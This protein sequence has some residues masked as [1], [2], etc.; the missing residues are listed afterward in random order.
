MLPITTAMTLTRSVS[1]LPRA[2][3]GLL[4]AVSAIMKGC[5]P[6][7]SRTQ[8][9]SPGR[10]PQVAE[11][12]TRGMSGQTAPRTLWGFGQNKRFG[13]TGPGAFPA[14]VWALGCT[15][16][17]LAARRERRLDVP[18]EDL[19][20]FCKRWTCW[21][22]PAWTSNSGAAF[23]GEVH[24]GVMRYRSGSQRVAPYGHAA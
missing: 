8:P 2:E 14:V 21:A 11:E 4:A 17:H 10:R 9:C 16:F 6:R 3:S 22:S 7:Q 1:S 24:A 15:V 20:H 12:G 18:Y 23:S 19:G 5:G 13:R